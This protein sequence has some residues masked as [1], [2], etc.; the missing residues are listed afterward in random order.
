MK[1]IIFAGVIALAAMNAS[2][3]AG[4]FVGVTYAIGSNAGVGLTLLA[5]TVRHEDRGIAAAGVSYY[6]FASGQKIGIPIGVGYQGSNVAGIVG[7]DV[8]LGVPVVSG[9]YVNTRGDSRPVAAPAP[10]EAAK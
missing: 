4:A 10:V 5:T 1:K 3:D 8:L 7:Y 9:G 2:A 6:P